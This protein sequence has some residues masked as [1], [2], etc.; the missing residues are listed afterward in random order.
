MTA[1]S[2]NDSTTTRKVVTLNIEALAIN[3]L[4]YA[5]YQRDEVSTH[6]RVITSDWDID[7]YGLPMVGRRKDGSL[8]VVNGRQRIAAAKRAGFTHVEAHVFDSNGIVHEARKFLRANRSPRKVSGNPYWEA[9]HIAREKYA[10]WGESLLNEVGITGLPSRVEDGYPL[11]TSTGLFEEN[12]ARGLG[13]LLG[14][15]GAASCLRFALKV[16]HLTYGH[17]RPKD[18]MAKA[19]IVGLAHV[20]HDHPGAR[21]ED[22]SRYLSD[23]GITPPEL[24]DRTG[25]IG[26][27][28]ATSRYKANLKALFP[29]T[30]LGDA[31]A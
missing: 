9:A 17:M 29:A 13:K 15:D 25:R 23:V 1:T 12:Y 27:G 18:Y 6:V 8:W 2:N 28:S 26:N 5:P 19:V 7:Q 16:L 24:L 31:A 14:H 21:A 11:M 20:K 22:L 4:K 3:D 10:L 30:V